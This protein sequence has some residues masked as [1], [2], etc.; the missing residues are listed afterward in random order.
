MY[1]T[2][3]CRVVII[4]SGRVGSHCAMSLIPGHLADEIVL[5]DANQALAEAQATDLA[6]FAT[7]MGSGITVRASSYADCDHAS[8]VLIAAGR[9]RRPGETRLELQACGMPCEE[10]VG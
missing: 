4:G 9:G 8:F 1:R 5:I 6:D 10:A 7:G 3:S 2:H